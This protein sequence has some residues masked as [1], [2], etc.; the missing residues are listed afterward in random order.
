MELANPSVEGDEL[1][2]A[3]GVSMPLADVLML[4]VREVSTG[5]TVLA[6]LGTALGVSVAF[7]VYNVYKAAKWLDDWDP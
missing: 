6:L 5:R 1:V 2:G 7:I 4:E 3:D